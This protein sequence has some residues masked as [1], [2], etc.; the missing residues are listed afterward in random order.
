MEVG[1]DLKV[2]IEDPFLK[3]FEIELLNIVLHRFTYGLYFT[4][5]TLSNFY[6]DSNWILIDSI[7][8][9]SNN[10]GHF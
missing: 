1:E 10:L 6:G 2:D 9:N 7:L 8:V 4:M 5:S 3:D